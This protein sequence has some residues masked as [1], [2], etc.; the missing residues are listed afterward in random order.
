MV[1]VCVCVRV[2]WVMRAFLDTE[3]LIQAAPPACESVCMCVCGGMCVRVRCVMR[4]F[5]HLES[6]IQAPPPT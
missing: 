4:A 6:L 5:F 2:R 1:Y 3:P